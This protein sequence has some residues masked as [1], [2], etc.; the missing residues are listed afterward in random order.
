MMSISM[1]RFA[2]SILTSA[3]ALLTTVAAH[4]Q[5]QCVDYLPGPYI[6][7][8]V[9]LA[10]GQG[11]NYYLVGTC[12][13]A[14]GESV[15]INLIV[16]DEATNAVLIKTQAAT[17]VN[18]IAHLNITSL[19]KSN[20]LNDMVTVTSPDNPNLSYGDLTCLNCVD[21]PFLGQFVFQ[22]QGNLTD[23]LQPVQIVGTFLTNDAGGITGGE[24]DIVST[25]GTA[26]KVPTAGSYTYDQITS[27]AT[28]TLATPV[29][30]QSFDVVLNAA[31]EGAL[32]AKGG[33]L[34]G[35]GRLTQLN[36]IAPPPTRS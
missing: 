31:N 2:R 14:P 9:Q 21:V 24:A 35:T 18:G 13:L 16:Q 30:M 3:L 29:G 22:F 20:G 23:G 6:P 36:R 19:P 25:T 28:I 7:G 33:P 1:A 32:V 34:S 26:E 10:D 11:S 5:F 12:H 4:G 17:D 27:T 8:A 15:T